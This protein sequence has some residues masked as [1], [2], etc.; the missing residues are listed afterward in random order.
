MNFSRKNIELYTL[1]ITVSL[2]A[3]WQIIFI[4]TLPDADTDAYAHFIIARDIVRNGSN[5]SLHWVWLPLFHYIGAFFVLIGSEMQSIRFLNVIIWNS[6]PVILYFSLKKK[7]PESLVPLSAALLTALSPIGILMGTTAQ[8]EPLFAL[9]IL[10]FIINLENGKYITS[11]V[12]L[13]LACMLRYEAW[14]VLSGFGI[15]LLVKSVRE[16]SLRISAFHSS[17]KIIAVVLLPLLTIALWTV[18]RYRSD[19]YWFSFLHGTQEFASDALGQ[20][21]SI[22]GGFLKLIS[23]VFL[24]PIWIPFLF[25][26]IA[27]LLIPFGFKKFYKGNVIMFVVGISILA[28][29]SVSWV[30]KAN[31]GLSRHF[32]SIVIFYSLMSAYGMVSVTEYFK[33]Y[34]AFKS[35]RILPA[36]LTITIL[37]YTAIWLHQW[38]ENNLYT[39]KER[40]TATDFLKNLYNTESERGITFLS[41]DPVLEILT[42]INY[43]TFDHFFMRQNQETSDYI[44]TL[45]TSGKNTYIITTSKLEPF[46]KKFGTPIFESSPNTSDPA[47]IIILKL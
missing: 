35:G 45:K 42:K 3:L 4:I 8:P 15:Y 26:G 39:F 38:R 31:L 14:A 5:L 11:A 20:T 19:G 9:F 1:L 22:Q 37:I 6:I 29:I 7:E 12:I 36:L 43:K 27:V 10:L 41:N 18:L 25:T 40:K 32:T 13:S 16:K 33:K 46:L 24:Y 2:A 23:D 34:P 17:Y 44:L 47:R 30:M 21:N 28:F